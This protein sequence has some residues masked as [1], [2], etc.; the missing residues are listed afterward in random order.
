ML[1][2]LVV[3]IV[4]FTTIIAVNILGE[5]AEN[6]NED[7]V[8]QDLINAASQVQQIWDR[9]RILDGADKDFTNL[10]ETALLTKLNIAGDLEGSQV[11]NENGSYSL[12]RSESQIIIT[13]VPSTGGETIQT[14]VCFDANNSAWLMNTASPEADVPDGCSED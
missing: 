4:G 8:R 2:I 13:G 7:A 1:V 10:S 14:V 5:G 9:P 12:T 6:A 3:I 11:T